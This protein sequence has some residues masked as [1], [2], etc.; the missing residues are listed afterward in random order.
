MELE[1]LQKLV[2]NIG[3]RKLVMRWKNKSVEEYLLKKFGLRASFYVTRDSSRVDNKSTFPESILKNNSKEYYLL[4]PDTKY[5]E[6][7]EKYYAKWGYKNIDDVM[8]LIPKTQKISLSDDNYQGRWSDLYGNKIESKSDAYIELQGINS[9]INIGKNVKMPK[10]FLQIGNNVEV[11]IQDNVD[12]SSSTISIIGG[13]KCFID[14]YVVL[15][16]M[17]VFINTNSKL[18]I[19]EHCTFGSGRI[20]TGR[21]QLVKIGKDCLFSWDIVLLAHDGH[22]IYDVESGKCT[23]NTK[24]KRRESIIIEDHVW[25]GGEVAILPNTHIGMGSICAYRSLIKGN[26]PNN[27]IVAGSIGKVVRKNIAWSRNNISNDETDYY[28]IDKKYRGYT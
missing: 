9:S 23:N 11:I 20:R 6:K 28:K 14:S 7:D 26:I 1:I 25:V 8:W 15:G 19:G 12:L 18:I 16:G 13:G 24:G 10:S 21:N 5:V 22:M 2:T 17:R 27:C 4:L 3:N